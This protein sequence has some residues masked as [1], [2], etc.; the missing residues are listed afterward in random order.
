MK[1]GFLCLCSRG[2]SLVPRVGKSHYLERLGV[3]NYVSLADFVLDLNVYIYLIQDVT[4][5][6]DGVQKQKRLRDKFACDY[7][8]NT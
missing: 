2:L 5:N 7:M 4:I 8:C 3:C 1:H 6:N